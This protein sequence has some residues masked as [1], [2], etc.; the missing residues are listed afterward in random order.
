MGEARSDGPKWAARVQ[1][2]GCRE[3][4]VLEGAAAQPCDLHYSRYAPTPKVT[5]PHSEGN[6]AHSC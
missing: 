5:N 3:S 6:W 4:R 1:S 2:A